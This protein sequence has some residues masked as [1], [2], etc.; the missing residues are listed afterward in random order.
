MCVVGGDGLRVCEWGG[1]VRVVW[2]RG[3]VGI[4]DEMI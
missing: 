4:R 1:G 3:R 2:G